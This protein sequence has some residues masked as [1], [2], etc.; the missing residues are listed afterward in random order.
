[1]TYLP[2]RKGDG[3]F[4]F[5][6]DHCFSIRGQGTVLTGTILQG[7]VGINDVR[8]IILLIKGENIALHRC[9]YLVIIPL[10]KPYYLST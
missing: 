8:M 4:V 9:K 3:A 2:E 5:S 1:M 7:A 6:V 10:H